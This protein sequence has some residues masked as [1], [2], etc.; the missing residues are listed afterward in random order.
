MANGARLTK[1]EVEGTK[2]AGAGS[3]S[4]AAGAYGPTAHKLLARQ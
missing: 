1:V 2:V 3:S 4:G